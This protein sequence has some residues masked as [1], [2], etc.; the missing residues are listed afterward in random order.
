[1]RGKWINILIGFIAGL[2]VMLVIS[3]S[4][5]VYFRELFQYVFSI[6]NN[7]ITNEV[8][9]VEV[10]IRGFLDDLKENKNIDSLINEHLSHDYEY[11][12]IQNN[13]NQVE[14]LLKHKTTNF[15]LYWVKGDSINSYINSTLDL[16]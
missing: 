2:M 11:T 1:M 7:E 4:S 12:M 6:K 9:R 13:Q 10:D 5:T 16:K 3:Y 14:F 8:N 15:S